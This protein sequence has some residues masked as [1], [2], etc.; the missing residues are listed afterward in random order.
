MEECYCG[1]RHNARPES[2]VITSQDAVRTPN[3]RS[4][5][6]SSPN[7]SHPRFI[8]FAASLDSGGHRT[9]HSSALP[10]QY[11]CFV[12]LLCS[13]AS[14]HFT[15]HESYAIGFEVRQ[16]KTEATIS[17]KLSYHVK[18]SLSVPVPCQCA[19]DPSAAG[20]QYRELSGVCLEVLFR[21]SS[22]G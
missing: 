14:P 12:W 10:S 8:R 22:L 13:L 11:V 18:L 1:V 3:Q 2:A 16:A 17:V 15:L 4:S 9:D 5:S 7:P 21:R 19:R 6:I 20:Q